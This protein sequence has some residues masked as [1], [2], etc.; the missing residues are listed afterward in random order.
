MVKLFQEFEARM[1]KNFEQIVRRVDLIDDKLQHCII[2]GIL[3]PDEQAAPSSSS[4]I[5]HT[6]PSPK[7]NLPKKFHNKHLPKKLPTKKNLPKKFPK[8]NLP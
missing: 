1:S 3:K 4:F 8:K 6:I 5:P 7:N 2:Q